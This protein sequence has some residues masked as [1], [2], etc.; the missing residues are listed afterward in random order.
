MSQ[1]D[2]AGA[3]GF[4]GDGD[5]NSVLDSIVDGM[6]A[7]GAHDRFAFRAAF[8]AVKCG[9]DSTRSSQ[10]HHGNADELT[11]SLAYAL[12]GPSLSECVSVANTIGEKYVATDSIPAVCTNSGKL[13]RSDLQCWLSAPDEAQS[14]QDEFLTDERARMARLRRWFDIHVRRSLY[15]FS[16]YFQKI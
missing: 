5:F 7:C 12:V 10:R 8:A 4:G 11:G 6:A 13:S 16:V 3:S 2:N 9:T 1:L 15:L 14:A